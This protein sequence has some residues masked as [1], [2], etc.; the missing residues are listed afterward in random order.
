[1]I[2]KADFALPPS[3]RGAPRRHRARALGLVALLLAVLAA[4]AGCVAQIVPASA[5][6]AS[7]AA[8][9]EIPRAVSEAFHKARLHGM[10][11][12]RQRGPNYTAEG[13]T[14][15]GLPARIV[16]SGTTGAVLGLRVLDPPAASPR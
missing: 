14:A 5:G 16:I 13:L 15:G 6:G 2:R 4:P 8:E 11:N 7:P 3:R 10:A 1:M 12:L 9:P